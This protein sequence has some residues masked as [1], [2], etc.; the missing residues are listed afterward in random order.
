MSANLARCRGGGD[1]P[2]ADP[3]MTSSS[4]HAGGLSGRD[5]RIRLSKRSQVDRTLNRITLASQQARGALLDLTVANPTAVGIEHDPELLSALKDPRNR[6]YDPAPLG[7]P[8]ARAFLGRRLGVD[9]SRVVLAASTSELYGWILR[10]CAD[11]GDSIATPRPSYPLFDHLL[12][13]DGLRSDRYEL[14]YDG[15]WYIDRTSLTDSAR[16]SRAIVAVSPNN[17][18]GSYLS[19]DEIEG[20]ASTGLPIILDEVFAAYP[21]EVTPPPLDAHGL[22][23]LFRLGGLS[24][25]LGLP[26]LKLAWATVHGEPRLVAEALARLELI[27]DV[28]LSVATPVQHALP[29]LFAHG[30][31]AQRAIR[32][33]IDQN[34]RALRATVSQTELTA[35]LVAGGW[36]AVVEAPRFRT[37]EEWALTFLNVGV[38]V[39]PGYFYDTTEDALF[40]VSLLTP[41]GV[42]LEGIRRLTAQVGRECAQADLL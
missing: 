20:L 33:R 19:A 35:R 13:F 37:D 15:E 23:L 11:P 22:P 40:V 39:Q 34:L 16:A 7:L 38:K 25:E 42:F 12:R 3:T 18:T 36:Y 1:H 31:E 4:K 14:R 27:A 6:R 10:L 9:P 21:V 28:S 5:P 30:A 17:P 32:E 26:Q 8:S 2:S 24:K 41:P 29:M